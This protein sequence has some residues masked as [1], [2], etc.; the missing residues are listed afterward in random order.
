MLQAAFVADKMW[1]VFASTSSYSITNT[2]QPELPGVVGNLVRTAGKY[3]E[4]RIPYR[5][6]A[7]RGGIFVLLH[8]LPTSRRL[9]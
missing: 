5:R 6:R 7:A 4:L 8:A 2:K 1:G 3:K 9:I